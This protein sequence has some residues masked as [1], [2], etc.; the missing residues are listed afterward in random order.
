MLHRMNQS[1]VSREL[2]ENLETVT[3]GRASAPIDSFGK[4]L[5]RSAAP[6]RPGHGVDEVESK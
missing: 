4:I 6:F 2:D 5:T 1:I 3:Q